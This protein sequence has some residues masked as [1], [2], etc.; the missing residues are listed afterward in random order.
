MNVIQGTAGAL[1]WGLALVALIALAAAC[2][3]TIAPAEE[4]APAQDAGEGLLQDAP[5]TQPLESIEVDSNQMPPIHLD[6]LSTQDCPKIESPLDQIM[7]SEAPLETAQKLGFRVEGSKLQV[8]V[9]LRDEK[10]GF[11]AQFGAEVGKQSGT[12]VQAFVPLPR[13]CELA[14]TDNVLAIRLPAQAVAQ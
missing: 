8:I 11:L 9:I 6:N 4:P 3:P 1:V 10:S 12:Q 5:P 14:R 7:R 13:L 2:S